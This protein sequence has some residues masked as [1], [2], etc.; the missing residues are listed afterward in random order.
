MSTPPEFIV[1][2]C[3]CGA[4]YRDWFR[5]SINLSLDHFDDDYIERASSIT[6]P[7]C[8]SYSRMGTLLTRFENRHLS[9]QFEPV[10]SQPEVILYLERPEREQPETLQWI[11]DWV[12]QEPQTRVAQLQE[13]VSLQGEREPDHYGW[14]EELRLIARVFE[15]D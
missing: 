6:C 3:H 4:V 1:V 5:P 12:K 11:F 13:I 8:R 7:N 15:P 10:R 2:W 9:M 14:Y